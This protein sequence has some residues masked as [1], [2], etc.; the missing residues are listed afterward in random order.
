[1][2]F[3]PSGK[4]DIRYKL[5][6]HDVYFKIEA[7]MADV[8]AEIL[9]VHKVL[10]TFLFDKVTLIQLNT[11]APINLLLPLTTSKGVNFTETFPH[12]CVMF[13]QV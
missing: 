7:Q 5:Y 4:G 1:M 10:V 9:Y 6:T 12:V 3:L 2:G 11:H 8:N 13:S